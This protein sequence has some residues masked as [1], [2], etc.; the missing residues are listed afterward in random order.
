[1]L[2]QRFAISKVSRLLIQENGGLS[3]RWTPHE[4]Q[5]RF[6]STPRGVCVHGAQRGGVAAE[7]A[8]VH[9]WIIIK[10]AKM[11]AFNSNEVGAKRRIEVQ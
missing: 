5:A 8:G 1:M 4:R 10:I 9:R 2:H 11:N 3:V 6:T 7:M